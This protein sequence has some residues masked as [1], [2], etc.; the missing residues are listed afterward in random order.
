MRLADRRIELQGYKQKGSAKCDK[1]RERNYMSKY[2]YV[3]RPPAGGWVLEVRKGPSH[4]GNSARTAPPAGI[5]SSGA[6]QSHSPLPRGIG[7][8]DTEEKDRGTGPSRLGFSTP[9][10]SKLAA[11]VLPSFG[12]P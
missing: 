2:E 3:D 5:S 8:R 6:T 10:T 7:H 12:P 1:M 9:S 4:K 11:L